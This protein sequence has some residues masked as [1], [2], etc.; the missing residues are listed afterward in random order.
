MGKDCFHHSPGRRQPLRQ[1][2][3]E[4]R[5]IIE[6]DL[7]E[8]TESRNGLFGVFLH[9]EQRVGR[10]GDQSIKV[11]RKESS[12]IMVLHL[13]THMHHMCTHTEDWVNLAQHSVFFK[14]HPRQFHAM[15]TAGFVSCSSPVKTQGVSTSCPLCVFVDLSLYKPNPSTRL[16]LGPSNLNHSPFR[17]ATVKIQ[18]RRQDFPPFFSVLGFCDSLSLAPTLVTETV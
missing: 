6:M 1:N 17:L 7:R 18:E 2:A 13:H 15:E 12:H 5:K 14:C 11:K 9:S 10:S 8:V 4:F 16:P 3:D